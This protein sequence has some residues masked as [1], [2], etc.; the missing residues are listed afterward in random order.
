MCGIAGWQWD[1]KPADP[2][3]ILSDMAGR[4]IH[5]G[6]D[7]DGFYVDDRIGLAHRRLSIID[8]NTGKQPQGNEDGTV[9]VVFNG[10]IYNFMDL[11]KDLV[12]RGHK[13][14]TRSDTEVL[15][16]L[17]EDHGPDMLGKIRGMFAFA[18]YDSRDGTLFLARDRLG[19]KPLFYAQTPDGLLFASEL[20][21]LLAS[22]AVRPV[23][24][25]E[26]L[27]LYLSLQY[28]P[29]PASIYATIQKLPPAHYLLARNGK[30]ERTARYWSLS[31]DPKPLGRPEAIARLR[32]T[33]LEA[34]RIR[35][36]SDV[37]LGAFLSGGIDSTITVG[38]MTRCADR[39]VKTFSIGFEESDY[40][41]L[42]HAREA[43]RFHATD[44]RE[45]VV[46]PDAIELLPTL[47]KHHGE[48]FADSSAIPTYYLCRETRKH[49]T[50]ALSGDGGD[51]GFL[52]YNRYLAMKLM[53]LLGA[54]PAGVRQQMIRLLGGVRH[55]LARQAARLLNM[56]GRPPLQSY[57]DAVSHFTPEDKDRLYTPDHAARLAR[58]GGGGGKAGTPAE[59]VFRNFF[60]AH[61][62]LLQA[63]SY[64]DLHTYLPDDILAKVDIA[65]M[66]NS[67]ETRSA[68]LDQKVIEFAMSVPP[69]LKMRGFRKK[70][71]LKT[72]F[73]DLL[74]PTVQRRGKMGFGVP[75][76]HWFRRELK[77]FAEE[78][79]D[80]PPDS[81]KEIF[82]PDA[83][84][85]FLRDHVEFRRKNDQRLWNLLFLYTWARTFPVSDLR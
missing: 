67:L 63:L 74:P 60:P 32:E 68:F 15:V 29:A 51:E 75:L 17:W 44:H 78:A 20:N 80:R 23:L 53:P 33:M 31:P 55:K 64:L 13:M 54:C 9:Q 84:R 19:V 61:A 38:L 69:G 34:V 43:A 76:E 4:M 82:K 30:I 62:P 47:V 66:A 1:A 22:P 48:P 77:S 35:M 3:K 27:D 71:L 7:D 49:V 24:S 52:G 16:H 14:A 58:S 11:R 21:A 39:P 50:V 81:F 37:P 59:Q 46:R 42:H 70:H 65:S 45:F 8:L 12:A 56:S 40:S 41:E 18:I 85:N 83:A 57:L 72:A 28:V 10:E 6:P 25:L 73:K 5:R 79:L 2:R 26:S 36:I